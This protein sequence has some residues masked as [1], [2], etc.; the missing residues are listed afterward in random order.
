MLSDG[1]TSNLTEDD[2]IKKTIPAFMMGLVLC[3]PP[4]ALRAADDD[5]P[6]EHDRQK[7]I[8]Y[9]DSGARDYHVWNDNEDRAYRNYLRER[10]RDYR[11]FSRLAKRE[12]Q[13]Y[14]R[15]RH[16]HQDHDDDRHT[17]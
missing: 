13:D 12:Q 10:N 2:L 7:E 8:R 17:R 4:L 16:N 5:H 11:E 9:Y 14:W 3:A 6:N 15:W 1:A